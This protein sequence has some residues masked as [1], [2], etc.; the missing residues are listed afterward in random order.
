[1]KARRRRPVGRVD[2]RMVDVLAATRIQ[3]RDHSDSSEP[4]AAVGSQAP[5]RSRLGARMRRIQAVPQTWVLPSRDRVGVA[6]LIVAETFVFLIFVV[7]YLFY[8]GKS[9]TGPTPRQ[10]LSLPVFASACLFASSGT[11]VYAVRSLRRG[12]MRAF[13][14]AWAATV[15][16]GA[17]F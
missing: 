16:L 8:L 2:A 14:I 17:I 15:V 5:R 13:T 9:T 6:C 12:R 4:A 11:I 10:V 1:R 7:A 3:L